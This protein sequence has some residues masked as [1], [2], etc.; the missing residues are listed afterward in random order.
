MVLRLV[1]VSASQALV[2]VVVVM[3]VMV[4]VVVVVMVVVLRIVGLVIHVGSGVVLQML[5][6]P[7]LLVVMVVVVVVM[8]VVVLAAHLLMM[9]PLLQTCLV[10]VL[11]MLV[12]SLMQ[13]SQPSVV[14]DLQECMMVVVWGQVPRICRHEIW[15]QPSFLVA[16]DLEGAGAGAPPTG[17]RVW[18][19]S[20]PVVLVEISWW[21]V[22]KSN[23][24]LRLWVVVVVD[25]ELS[26]AHSH[27]LGST[28]EWPFQ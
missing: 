26:Q 8:I 3:V 2:M 21:R 28:P 9:T 22:V 25:H 20:Q 14:R 5:A 1:L 16:Q 17:R 18:E 23:H 27:V 12:A 15:A 24:I 13:G 19:G 7:T 6:E 10:V 4:V 11:W